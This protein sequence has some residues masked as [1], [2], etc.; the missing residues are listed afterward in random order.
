MRWQYRKVEVSGDE[1][2]DIP[3]GS[4]CIQ[5]RPISKK[6]ISFVEWIEPVREEVEYPTYD[7]KRAV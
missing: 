7:E 5:I 2:I 1:I 3:A 4:K 6:D